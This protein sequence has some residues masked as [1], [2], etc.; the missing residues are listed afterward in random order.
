MWQAGAHP[1]RFVIPEFSFE[2]SEKG[3]SGIHSVTARQ[4]ASDAEAV[5][6]SP[7]AGRGCRQEG[8]GKRRLGR[9]W[10]KSGPLSTQLLDPTH[11][12]QKLHPSLF[13]ALRTSPI[14]AAIALA[15]DLVRTGYQGRASVPDWSHNGVRL[16]D[17]PPS[18]GLDRAFQRECCSPGEARPPD[19][20][21]QGRTIYLNER[22]N[23]RPSS[24][25]LIRGQFFDNGQ[26]ALAGRG[27]E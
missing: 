22:P 19:G 14:I 2:R 18:P 8:E 26:T 3:M 27:N 12:P 10:M 24:R 21:P 13:P 9:A 17:E 4:C 7:P 15:G 25:P 23:G 20:R 5:L 16:G 11:F 6:L 1:L